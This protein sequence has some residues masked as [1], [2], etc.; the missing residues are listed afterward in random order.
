M[1]CQPVSLSCFEK[2]IVGSSGSRCCYREIYIKKKKLLW[3]M[4]KKW[5]LN[6]I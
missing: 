1:Q 3:A 6:K 4:L 5:T 2:C